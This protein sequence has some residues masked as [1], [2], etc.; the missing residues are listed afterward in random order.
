[1]SNC[2]CCAAAAAFAALRAADT[3]LLQIDKNSP[4]NPLVPAHTLQPSARTLLGPW[5]FAWSHAAW[6]QNRHSKAPHVPVSIN[7]FHLVGVVQL[8][9]RLQLCE[10]QRQLCLTSSLPEPPRPYAAANFA[11][12]VVL[13]WFTFLSCKRCMQ[14]TILDKN[15]QRPPRALVLR[16]CP[17][18]SFS[19]ILLLVLCSCQSVCGSASRGRHFTTK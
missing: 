4:R 17:S 6:H 8:P 16:Q 7:K 2:W 5:C 11:D 12:V 15:L 13:E 18:T 9:Q 19:D 14:A 10:P 3:A 1:M